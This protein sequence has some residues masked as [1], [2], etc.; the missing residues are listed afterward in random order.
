MRRQL[1]TRA[2]FGNSYISMFWD[3]R[4]RMIRLDQ[5]QRLSQASHCLRDR[6]PSVKELWKRDRQRGLIDQGRCTPHCP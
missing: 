5:I 4:R 2:K 3:S 1:Y 6:L